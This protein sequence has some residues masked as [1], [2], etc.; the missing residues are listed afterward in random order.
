MRFS[1]SWGIAGEQARTQESALDFLEETIIL[2]VSMAETHSRQRYVSLT[3]IRSASLLLS[4]PHRPVQLE[5]CPV[6][7]SLS[8]TAA[9]IDA[10]STQDCLSC[11][12]E[13]FPKVA[14]MYA[15][16][17]SV[18]CIVLWSKPGGAY[19]DCGPPMP[20]MWGP[21]TWQVEGGEGRDGPRL[22]LPR[23]PSMDWGKVCLFLR[24]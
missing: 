8:G 13:R 11:A 23:S 3:A 7:P 22:Y 20:T 14:F 4:P 17:A 18:V 6:R 21:V 9:G 5:V 2:G 24:A 10:V 12:K 16:K 19:G 15:E 1:R